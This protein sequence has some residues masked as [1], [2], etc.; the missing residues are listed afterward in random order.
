MAPKGSRLG[1]PFEIHLETNDSQEFQAVRHAG[2]FALECGVPKLDAPVLVDPWI[3][4]HIPYDLEHRA[5][6]PL[7]FDV[8]PSS[9]LLHLYQLRSQLLQHCAGG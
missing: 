9:C 6:C 7:Q 2:H 8:V 1:N 3:L 5:P 4:G